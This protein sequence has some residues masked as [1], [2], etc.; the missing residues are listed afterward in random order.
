[1]DRDVKFDQIVINAKEAAD[2]TTA[3]FLGALEV[4]RLVNKSYGRWYYMVARAVP[5][6][7]EK[8][9]TI[10]ATGATSYAVPT[11]YAATM[12]MEHTPSGSNSVLEIPRV[13]FQERNRWGTGTTGGVARGFRVARLDGSNVPQ[14]FFYPNPTSGDY[15]HV[16]LPVPKVLEGSEGDDDSI[17]GVFGWERWI[18]LDV[19]IQLLNKEESDASALVLERA[20]IERE[21]E[22][23]ASDRN[24]KTPKRVVDVR[25]RYYAY[26][27][28]GFCDPDLWV[29]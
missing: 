3:N 11:D 28:P 17:D 24:M 29:S 23:A 7:F 27:K 14:V 16:Y 10:T 21:I 25:A 20:K 1:M 4:E 6:R 12:A 13:M 15:T 22:G 5:E 18:E 2:M 26:G 8:T 9:Q 19:A